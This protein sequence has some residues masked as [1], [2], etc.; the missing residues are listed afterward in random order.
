M[1]NKIEEIE[2][3]GLK[4]AEILRAAE[5]E[6]TNDFLRVCGSKKGRVTLALQ[7]RKNKKGHL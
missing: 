3:I 2:G 7:R 6:T 5:I 1:A 4:Y